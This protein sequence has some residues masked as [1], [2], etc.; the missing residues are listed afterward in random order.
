MPEMSATL[1]TSGPQA[2]PSAESLLVGRYAE[3]ALK[4]AN[5]PVFERALLRRARQVLP[6]GAAAWLSGSRLLVRLPP[7]VAAEEGEAALQRCFGLVGVQR[8]LRLPRASAPEDLAAACVRLADAARR[9]GARTFKVAARR[10][11]KSYPLDSLAL[12]RVLGAAVARE[13]GL[14][15]DVRRPDLTLRVEVRPDG[16]YAAGAD[17]PG[18]GGLPTGTAGRALL[19]LSGGIDSPVAGWLAARRG[20]RLSAVYF[21]TAPYT[22]EGARQKVLDLARRLAAYAGPVRVWLGHFTEIQ[23]A[24]AAAVPEPLRTVVVRRMMLRVAEVLGRRERAGAL[25][26]GDSLGQVASQTL[27][28]LAAVGEVATLPLLR[29]LIAADKTEIIA[30]A[31]RIGTYDVSVRPFADCCT[32][33]APRHPRTRPTREEVRRA[34]AALDVP[35]LVAGAV[36]R[37]ERLL[38]SADGVVPDPPGRA[39]GGGDGPSGGAGGVTAPGGDAP[40]TPVPAVREGPPLPP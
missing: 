27:E 12:N 4:G 8:A 13:T 28:A 16:L 10:A 17:A 6:P 25:V 29:P 24:I 23:L 11:D 15:V 20:L 35:A 39:C 2:G 33:F 26:T 18:P 22:G 34:E 21:D 19:L 30:L 40:P 7:G 5:R 31:R 32:L 9:A 36:A 3:V 1:G 38:A 37:S 14:G